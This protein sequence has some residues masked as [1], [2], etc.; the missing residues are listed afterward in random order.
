MAAEFNAYDPFSRDESG[1]ISPEVQDYLQER[2]FFDHDIELGVELPIHLI[3]MANQ[4]DLHIATLERD[5]G[6]SLDGKAR[7]QTQ[8]D[9][10]VAFVEERIAARSTDVEHYPEYEDYSEKAER[11]LSYL[12]SKHEKAFPSNDNAKITLLANCSRSQNK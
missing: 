10:K 12:G 9:F 11:V 4:I 6:K 5:T 1:Q 3:A 2:Q 7:S 8:R